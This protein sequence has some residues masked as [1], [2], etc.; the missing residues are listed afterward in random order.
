[1]L[2]LKTVMLNKFNLK[3]IILLAAL[4]ASV[5]GL[6]IGKQLQSPAEKKS[7]AISN[8]HGTYLHS[9]RQISAFELQGIDLQK[10]NNHSFIGQWTILFFGFT[11]CS[12]V[13][14]TIMAELAKMYRI[15]QISNVKLLPRVVM[16]SLDPKR[17]SLAKLTNYV[18]TFNPDFYGARG[19]SH[20]LKKI[21]KEMGVAYAKIVMANNKKNY[22][23]QHTGALMLVNPHGQLQA[24]F[25]PP[26]QANL[27]AQD[28]Q[29]LVS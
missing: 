5:A 21:T 14:P 16:I 8:F 24:F 23:I 28:Y 27:L 3:I 9:P 17:D 4:A 19:E 12:Y 22:D 29:L 18:K 10:F 20:L 11:N 15:L 26:H 1:M 13:C 2:W 25:T 7:F 6:L